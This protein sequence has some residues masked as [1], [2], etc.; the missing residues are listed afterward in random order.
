M[1]T[2]DATLTSRPRYSVRIRN[3]G[4]MATGHVVVRPLTIFVGP[5]NSGKSYLAT[6]LY[7]L[8]GS[9][10]NSEA[11]APLPG[12][13]LR[14]ADATAI[15]ALDAWAAET[16]QAQDLPPIP[17]D[18]ASL[19]RSVVEEAV[20]LDSRIEHELGRCFGV[21][22]PGKLV[23]FPRARVAHVDLALRRGNAAGE[24]TYNLRLTRRHTQVNG[25]ISGNAGISRCF[26]DWL[27]NRSLYHRISAIGRQL[28]SYQDRNAMGH[29]W[30]DYPAA[31]RDQPRR[32]S[33]YR[34]HLLRLLTDGV[35]RCLTTPL[36]RR[37]HYLPADRTGVM[38]SHK[39]VVS[40]LVRNA[41]TAGIR[42]A[43][44]VPM[45]SGVLADFLDSLIQIPTSGR[46]H[47]LLSSKELAQ[48][49][50]ESVL[51]GVVHVERNETNYPQFFF[52]PKGWKESL[53]LMRA[54]SMVSELAPIVLYLR[55]IVCRGDLLI[56][57]EPEAHLHPAMQVELVRLLAKMVAAG[58]Q[59]IVTTHSSWILE[60]FGNLV[61]LS[62]LPER[63]RVG[64]QSDAA[65]APTDVGVWLFSMPQATNGSTV[66]EIDIDPDTGLFPSDYDEVSEALYNEGADIFNRLQEYGS[67]QLNSR[68]ED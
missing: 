18:L 21:N 47:R 17:R 62:D 25:K 8:H 61:K 56:I 64:I 43:A 5:S 51:G 37:V 3:F 23:R 41:A 42:P 4:P 11:H 13:F 28:L 48:N 31:V 6:L 55:Y 53:P 66:E 20:G 49:L 10:R 63:H 36:A 35:Q 68:A 16:A 1:E 67:Y 33:Y 2:P 26:S 54:S 50:E 15:A 44:D 46:A 22:D 57:E 27:D 40:A 60:Q 14:G 45:L 32:L 24:F 30:P 9:L 39:V 7:A 59:V 29:L 19:V 34:N 58:V 12:S 65:L 38:H 52:R